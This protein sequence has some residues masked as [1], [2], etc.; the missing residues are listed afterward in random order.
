M[1]SSSE[2]RAYPN[3]EINYTLVYNNHPEI[4]SC[5]VTDSK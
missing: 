2:S 5:N 1:P 3:T 4:V